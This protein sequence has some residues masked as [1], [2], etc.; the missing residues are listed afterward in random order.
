MQTLR[1][2]QLQGKRIKM[3]TQILRDGSETVLIRK[4]NANKAFMEFQE[5][6]RIPSNKR[7]FSK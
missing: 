3:S 7:K 5:G 4:N 6:L 1:E 2:G